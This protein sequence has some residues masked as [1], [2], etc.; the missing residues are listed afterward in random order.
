MI[1]LSGCI[2]GKE[3]NSLSLSNVISPRDVGDEVDD[4]VYVDI[5]H[6]AGVNGDVNNQLSAL[7]KRDVILE[8]CLLRNQVLVWS[9]Q[10]VRVP[11]VIV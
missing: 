5:V 11:A 2:D 8:E 4:V 7:T 6:P 1:R 10:V 9:R 3:G